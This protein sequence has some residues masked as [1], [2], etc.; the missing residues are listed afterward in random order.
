MRTSVD[1]VFAI[2]DVRSKQL[3]QIVNAA[4][5]GAVAAFSVERYLE[6]LVS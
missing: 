6:D 1:G 2:G 3:R 5:E 4:G